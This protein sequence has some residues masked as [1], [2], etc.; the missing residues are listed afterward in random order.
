MLKRL[1]NYCL[2]LV[3]FTILVFFGSNAF[4]RNSVDELLSHR[5]FYKMS[6]MKIASSSP[7]V[8]VEGRLSFE[9]REL[10]DSW[11]VEQSYVMVYQ[12]NDGSEKQINTFLSSWE[13]R[14]GNNY[15]FF[16]K[17]KDSDASTTFIEGTAIMPE[18]KGEGSVDF[19]KPESKQITLNKETLFPSKHTLALINAAK[20][21]QKIFQSFIFDGTDIEPSVLV[22]SIIGPQRTFNG[23]VL[24]LEKGLYWPIRMAFFS[25]A[26]KQIEPEYEITINLHSNGVVSALILDYGD[27]IIDVELVELNFLENSFCK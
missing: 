13:Q 12:S 11:T 14:K 18:I 22:S 10:C 21:K 6:A 19:E 5:A 2:G 24:E 27:I 25:P 15:K 16:V 4:S 17:H 8:N 9:L 1:L 23:D 7:I 20:R 3:I 26:E